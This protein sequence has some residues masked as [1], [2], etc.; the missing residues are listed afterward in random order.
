MYST[1]VELTDVVIEQ[2]YTTAF[3]PV[4]YGHLCYFVNGMLSMPGGIDGL[5]NIFEVDR[6]TFKYDEAAYLNDIETYG[7][8][9]YQ[10]FSEILLVSEEL[11]EAVNGQYLKVA[12]GKGLVDID[13]LAEYIER[14]SALFD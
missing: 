2:E 7:L 3:S 10:E 1:E 6:E 11:F 13:T 4:T 9:T 8:Y 14:Y 5:F 12:I